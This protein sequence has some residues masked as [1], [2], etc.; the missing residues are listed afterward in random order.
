MLGF[1]LQLVVSCGPINPFSGS[2][3][4][5]SLFSLFGGLQSPV[6]RL[7]RL[8]VSC[9]CVSFCFVV[10]V[11]LLFFLVQLV[12]GCTCSGLI[13]DLQAHQCSVC[14]GVGC[15]FGCLLVD[16]CW[17]YGIQYLF[18]FIFISFDGYTCQVL[19]FFLHLFCDIVRLSSVRVTK[20]LLVA[21][22]NLSIM[23]KVLYSNGGGAAM[24]FY[25]LR[26]IVCSKQIRFISGASNIEM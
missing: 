23:Y 17:V 9:G 5:I 26:P 8:V 19:M 10:R 2:R 16:M 21:T 6:L 14:W 25:A 12:Y 7:F 11:L 22:P 15:L 1:Y 4:A 20:M 3:L 18:L 13:V 24:L